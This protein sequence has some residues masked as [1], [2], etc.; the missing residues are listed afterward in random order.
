[1]KILKIKLIEVPHRPLLNG[2][3]LDFIDP[4]LDGNIRP[5]IFIGINGSG[6]SQLL[7][8]IAEIFLYLDRLYRKINH[9]AVTNI[10]V[11]F[12]IVYLIIYKKKILIVTIKQISHSSKEPE[13]SFLDINGQPIKILKENFIDLLP[14][15]VIGYTSG[16]NETLSL[17]FTDY[18]DEYA[19]YTGDRALEDK[20]KAMIDY[21]PRFYLMDYNTNI[22]VLI[23]NLILGN[24]HDVKELVN[25]VGIDSLKS[26]Q[27]IIQTNH[28]AAPSKNGVQLTSELIYWIEQLR[29]A[30]TCYEYFE[31]EKK[32]VL[33]F[34]INNETKK[35][36]KFFFKTP[37]AF[38]TALY[39]IE[40]LNN[41]I[42]KDAQ[43]KEIKKQR[44]QRKLIIKPPT[45][46]EY[47]KVLSYSEVKLKLASGDVVNYI[48]LS[49]GEHQ[50]LNIFGTVLMTDF[51][52][53]LY[54]LD[55]PETHFNPKWRREFISIL[56]KIAEKRKQDFFITSHSPFIVADS[57]REQVFIFKRDAKNSL[58]VS[59]PTEETYGSDTDFILKIAF[60]LN[61]SLA[62]NSYDEIKE[63]S[64]SENSG[65]IEAKISEFGD[66][67]EKLYL[68][69]RIEELKSKNK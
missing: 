51:P 56:T 35:A 39:K 19:K 14:A 48:N 31:K 12:E 6:K 2:L 55:E 15:K 52:N 65:T 40:L 37:I 4:A 61:T 57:K 22:G 23:S 30:A 3:D 58:H 45:V 64:Q 26:F 10:P 53:S 1:M 60:D 16:D 62:K 42:I 49:D 21:D 25:H 46:A 17:P 67:A 32:H 34:H 54:L 28:P 66:S 5:N 68:F 43:L 63:L 11:L 36:I 47:D 7:E 59:N 20:N 27:I 9:T 41:L 50:Y 24:N 69:K 13:V 18:Y 29:N 44:N 33:D 38:Y 8:T